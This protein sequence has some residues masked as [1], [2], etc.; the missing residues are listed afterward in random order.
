MLQLIKKPVFRIVAPWAI[1]Y[2]ILFVPFF[3]DGGTN[4]NSRFAAMRAMSMD[5]VLYI[6]NYLEWTKDWSLS[7]DCHFYSNK[8]PGP[9]ILAFPVFWLIDKTKYL[10]DPDFRNDYCL[11][12]T[13]G[14][15]HK[16]GIPLL[17]QI[18]PFVLLTFLAASFLERRGASKEAILFSTIAILFANTASLFM[19]TWFGHGLT[20]CLVLGLFFTLN[21]NRI[22]LSGLLFGF[23]LLSEYSVALMLPAIALFWYMRDELRWRSIGFFIIGGI[24]P[25]IIWCWYHNTVF[26]GIFQLPNA[27][28]NPEFVAGATGLSGQ[29][30]GYVDLK[31]TLNLLLGSERGILFTQPWVLVFFIGLVQSFEKRPIPLKPNYYLIL[32][33]FIL[34]LIMN[35]S[36]IGWHGGL[37][38][39]PRY[40]A[41]VMPLFA[42]M[43]ALCYDKFSLLVK[44][45]LWLSVLVGVVLCGVVY[46][47]TILAYE[48]RVLWEWFGNFLFIYYKV[49]R[50]I[51]FTLTILVAGFFSFQTIKGIISDNQTQ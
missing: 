26:G 7:D 28:Q 35:S 6:D 12:H 11:P 23:A 17:F 42:I 32:T 2:L 34:L 45:M 46:N 3:E 20:A 8:A 22:I 18:L 15:E 41:F 33:T 21:A 4:P 30:L 48:H 38:P 50:I 9:T 19:P 31:I 5:G 24:L 14:Y 10:V 44:I 16:I 1:V 37:T 29:F 47:A 36:F 13:I 25:G 49:E 43:T 51:I 39:G 27:F 40:L